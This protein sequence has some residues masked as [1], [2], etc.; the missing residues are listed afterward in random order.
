MTVSP[1]FSANY[2]EAREKFLSASAERGL[3]VDSRLNPNAKGAQGEELFTDIIRIG[4]ATAPT[5]LVLL[6]ATHGVE[7]Y[8]GSGV[9]V[10]LLREGYF[11][12]LPEALSIVMV[13]AM[14]PYGFSHD[15]RV[16]EDNI[17]LNRNFLDFDDP[18]RPDCGYSA[19]HEWL[20]PDDWD[21]PARAQANKD[22]ARF[23]EENGMRA[24]QAAVSGGQ[25]QHADGIFYGGERPS[26]S[27]ETF[28]AVLS[29][30][31]GHAHRVGVIDFHTGLGPYGYGEP[32]T[33]G[34]SKQKSLAK[35][36]YGDAVTDPDSGDSSSAPV[37]GST[38]DAVAQTLPD[39]D[40]A[41]IALEYGTRDLTTVLTSLRADNWLYAKGDVDSP[42]GAQIKAEIR[43][44]CYPDADDW[45]AAV[46]T[47]A[48]EII[49]LAI[50]GLARTR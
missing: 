23:I 16:N 49:D 12:E 39:A 32:I 45:K 20:V 30:Y 38:G 48:V 6:S 44:A 27:N 1:H 21:G 40:I 22:L 47:R 35:Q 3:S 8:C 46:W 9:Q 31:A 50:K 7:G 11:S 33:V 19:L 5:V 43:D 37:V 29:D 14:N 26:W 15:R 13:H 4:S 24:F 2:L 10:G 42:L 41:F 17:D 34:N 25:Y 36:W 28:R 18:D